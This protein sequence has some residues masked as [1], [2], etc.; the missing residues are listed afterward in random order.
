M[1]EV[2]TSQMEPRIVDRRRTVER[3]ARRRR[4]RVYAVAGAVLVLVAASIGALVSPLLDID[5]VTVSGND[6]LDPGELIDASGVRRGNRLIDVDV[7]S[8]RRALMSLPWVASARVVRDWP[9][10]VR[11][12]VT[13]ERPSLS[14]VAPGRTVLVSTTGRVLEVTAAPDPML[15]VLEVPDGLP[16]EAAARGA[17]PDE[18]VGRVLAADLQHVTA[19]FERIPPDLRGELARGRLDTDGTLSFELG[20]GTTVEFGPP[21]DVAAKLQSVQGVLSQV[22]RECMA[23]LDVRE[24]S[25]AA[26]SRVGGCLGDDS[27]GSSSAGSSASSSDSSS[28]SSSASSSNSGNAER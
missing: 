26:V 19:V 13:E 4:H 21:E 15:P 9:D 16:L 10:A 6:R 25:R 28:T 7:Q 11:I 3:A 1:P 22:Q 14:V 2:V 24:P 5:R 23:T 17:D 18:V 20:D 12:T 8:A 27:D